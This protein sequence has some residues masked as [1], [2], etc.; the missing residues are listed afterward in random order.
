MKKSYSYMLAIITFSV[1]ILVALMFTTDNP[2]YDLILVDYKMLIDGFIGTVAI[3]IITLISSMILGFLL[4]LAEKSKNNIVHAFSVVFNEIVM[5]T[6]L[7]VMIFLAV[8]VVGDLIF[9][10]NKFVLGILALTLYMAPYLSNAYKTAI[11]VVD[12]D[13]YIVMDLYHFTGYQRYKYIIFPQMIKPLLPSLINNLSSI[14]K[15]SALLKIVS[16]IEISYVLTVVSSKNWAVIE[17]YYMMWILYLVIT[18][19]LSLLAK[20]VAKKVV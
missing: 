2:R 3:S 11:A 20:Y 9:I 4:F 1:A 15:G 16:V 10:S 12:D 7:L 18:I 19:P 6:P 13:Q 14:I 8:Y 17:G 5:G